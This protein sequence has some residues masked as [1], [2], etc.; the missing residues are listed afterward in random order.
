MDDVIIRKYL[1][2]DKYEIQ[3]QNPSSSITKKNVLRTHKSILKFVTI[4]VI[5]YSCVFDPLRL[6][7]NFS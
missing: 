1:I 3:Y 5:L 6:I 7:N 4:D 2:I